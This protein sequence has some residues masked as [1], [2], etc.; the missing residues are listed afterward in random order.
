LA[1]HPLAAIRLGGLL[2][3]HLWSALL[4]VGTFC[5]GLAKT[6]STG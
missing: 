2:Y 4:S 6:L 1:R 5:L 3:Y